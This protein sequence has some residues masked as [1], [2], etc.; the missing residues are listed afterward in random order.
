MSLLNDLRQDSRFDSV[1]DDELVEALMQEPE[2]RHMPPSI[3]RASIIGQEAMSEDEGKGFIAGL[4]SGLHGLGM[5]A[6]GLTA[7]AGEK[8]QSDSLY[9][10]GTSVYDSQMEKAAE[11]DLGYGLSDFFSPSDDMQRDPSWG[12]YIAYQVGAFLPSS[13]LSMGTGGV[14]GLAAKGIT[15]LATRGAVKGAQG[16][17]AKGA[18]EVARRTAMARGAAVGQGLG[19]WAGS[20]GQV[21]GSLY[22]ELGDSGVAITHGIVGGALESLFPASM[23]RVMSPAKRAAL[24]GDIS[25]GIGRKV[26]EDAASRGVLKNIGSKAL[27]GA[28]MEGGTEALQSL[29]EQH[30]KH[31]VETN[32]ES[33][34]AN[35]GE[36]DWRG[37]VDAWGAGAAGGGVMGAPGGFVEGSRARG[38][39]RRQDAIAK[40]KQEAEA[41]GGDALD[42]AMAGQNAEAEAEAESRFEQ[43]DPEYAAEVGNRVQMAMGELDELDNLSRGSSYQG[44]TRL[45]NIKQLLSR[46]EKSYSEGNVEQASRYTTRAE[47]IAMN[48]RARL[49]E[50]GTDERP[51]QV[52]G[53][54]VDDTIQGYIG[55]N[56]RYL[57]PGRD[58]DAMPG[59]SPQQ[60]EARQRVREEQ[61]A[62][63]RSRL[64]TD[65]GTIYAGGTTLDEQRA[66]GRERTRQAFEEK[67]GDAPYHGDGEYVGPDPLPE[68]I[69]PES[70]I[71]DGEVIRRPSQI[72]GRGT[73]RLMND[74]TIYAEGPVAG[75][76]NTGMDQQF[77]GARNTDTR[78][79]AGQ[80]LVGTEAERLA[81]WERLWREQGVENPSNANPVTIDIQ[82]NRQDRGEKETTYLP[83]NTPIDTQFRVVDASELTVSNTPDGRVNPSYPAELQP[84]DRTNAN[85]QVQ[86]RNIAARLNPE[87]LGSSTD[88]GTGA[89]IIGP[90]GV[91]ESGNGRAMAIATAYSQDGQKA[92][93]YRD[94][95]RSQAVAQGVPQEVVDS[96]EQPVLVRERATDIDRADFARRANE[97]SV[98]GMTS[99]EQAQ[100]DADTLTDDDIRAWTPDQSGDPLAASNRDFQRRFVQRLG[101]NEAARYTNRS[102]QASPELGVRMQRA[103]FAKAYSDDDMVEL[104]TE[105]GD[106]MRNLTASLQLAAPDLASARN[107]GS[108]EAIDAIGHINDAVRLVRKSRRDDISVRELTRQDDAFSEPVPSIVA[109]LAVMIDSNMR[110][111]ASLSE[112]M[113]S[114][115]RSVRHRADSEHSGALFEDTTTNEDV[116]NAAF[117][118]QEAGPGALE[119]DVS[120]GAGQG[121]QEAAGRRETD[122]SERLAD[123]EQQQEA[124]DDRPLL[125]DDSYQDE[126]Q[127]APQVHM[128]VNGKPFATKRSAEMST[129]FRNTPG[130]VA[131]EVDGGWG[132]EVPGATETVS[133][134]PNVDAP[135]DSANTF[136]LETQT[137]ESRLAKEQELEQAEKAEAER[138]RLL[139]ERAQADRDADDFV[140]S[141]SNS[142]ADMAMARGQEDIF[143]GQQQSTEQQR[144]DAEVQ[145]ADAEMQNADAPTS[146]TDDTG[147]EGTQTEEGTTSR[148]AEPRQSGERIEDFG[149]KIGGARKD[150]AM[151]V[152]DGLGSEVTASTKLSEAFPAPNY[153]KLVEEGVD[154]RAAAFVAVV[155]NSVPAKPRKAF[156]LQRWISNLKSAQELARM[157]LEKDGAFDDL[158]AK[159]STPE[160]RQV[161]GLLITAEV[162]SQLKPSL[163]AKAAKWRVDVSAGYTIFNGQK[164]DPNQAVYRLKDERGRDTGVWSENADDI[165]GKASSAI[166]KAVQQDAVKPKSRQ[167]PVNIYRNIQTGDR[168]IAFKAGSRVIRLQGGFESAS[169]AADYITE[170]RD[171]IQKQ[172][173]DMRAGPKMRGDSNAPREGSE[174]RD[175]DVTPDDFQ[176]AFGFRGVEFGNYVEGKRRQ[177]DLNRAYDAL[178]DLSTMMGVPPKAMS[179]DGT[180]G[181]AFG[182]RGRGGKNAAAA[183]YEPGHVVINLTK[184]D[185]AG[186]LAHEWFHALDNYIPHG[187]GGGKYQTDLTT[188]GSA[189]SELAERWREMRQALKDSGFE[190]RSKEFDAP[191]SKAY[192][193][194]PIEMAARAF[195]KYTK[196]KLDAQGVRNDYLVN[197]LAEDDGP[198]PNAD[199]SQSISSAFDRLMGTLE[200]KETARGVALYSLNAGSESLKAAL[201]AEDITAAIEGAEGLGDVE[202]VQSVSRLPASV[203]DNMAAN[204]IN[205]RDVSGVYVGDKMYVVADNVDSIEGGVRAAVHEAV[206]HKGIR[207]V[208]GESLD[209]VMLGLYRSL[210]NSKAGREALKEVLAAYPHLD[211]KNRDDRITIGEEMVAHMLEKGERPKAWQRAVAKIREMLRRAFPSVAW[212]YTDVLL[213]GEKS[214]E[215]LGREQSRRLSESAAP[216]MARYSQ[217]NG[218]KA[219]FTPIMEEAEAY[220]SELSKSDIRERMP[221]KRFPLGRTPPVLAALGAPDLALSV[222]SGVIYKA[223][224]G[225]HSVP[226]ELIKQLPELLHDP[227]MVLDSATQ[228][229]AFVVMVQGVDQQ[230]RPV[231]VP[232]QLNKRQ[233]RLEVN[234]V[235][236]AYGR[237]NPQAFIER[238]LAEGRG[239]YLQTKK[240]PE[241][242][243]SIR[244]QLPGE[245]VA[246]GLNPSILTPDDIG[247][248][249]V[250]YSLRSKTRVPFEDQFD[251][252]GEADRA[253]GGKIGSRTPP[254]RA[255]QWFKE[256]AD[257][258]SLK[259]RQGMVDKVA[260]F[261]EMDEQLYG[262]SMLGEN[263]ARSSWVLA[264][265]SNAASGALHALMHNGRIKMEPDEK[266]IT[267]QEGDAKGLGEVL[268]RLGS[269]AEIER[270][271]GWIA[272]N[273]AAKL[274]GEGRENLFNAEDIGAMK[275]WNRG[276]M[277]DG[278]SR[279]AVYQEVFN[280]FQTYRDDVLAIAEQ[281][282]II[283]KDQREMW[284]D[285]FYVPFYRLAEDDNKSP[286][287]ELATKGLS[288]QQAYKKL[289]GGSQNLNDLLQN[290]MMNF[291]HL[292]D[293]SLKNQAAVQAVHNAKELGMA[294]EV[295]E[296]GRDT[297]KT[298][299]V[300]EGGEK[301]FYE[302]DDPLVFQALTAMASPGMNSTAMKVMRGFKRVFTNMVTTTPQFMAANLIRDSLQAVATNNVS[303]NAF[304]NVV[305][306][307]GKYRDERLRAEMMASGASFNFGHLYGSNPDEMRAQL[308]RHMRNAEL[309][310]G[311]YM[312]P[313]LLRAGWEKW[314]AINNTAENVNRAA[315]YSQNMEQGK[316]ALA[317]A[318]E[319]RDLIDF[320]SHGAWPATRILI[321]IVPFLNARIQGLDKIYRSGVKPGASVVAEAFGY[322]KAGVTEKQAAGRFWAV[323]GAL[324]LATVALYLHNEEDEEY[325]KLEEWQKDSYWFFRVGDKAFFIPKPFEVGAIA[326]MAE[327]I[328]QQF[329]DDKATGK[330]FRQRMMHMAMD[331]FSF[332]PTPQ[333]VQPA[334]DIYANKDSFT[335]RPIEGMGMD[336]LSPELRKRSNTT[337]AAEWISKGLNSTVGAIGSPE[338]NPLALS[339]VQVDHLIGGYLG[340]V[341]SWVA[342]SG[343][344]A[345]RVATG[346]TAPASRWHEYQPI[347]RFYRDLGQEDFY[348]RY[349]TVFYEGLREAGRAYSDAKELRELGRTKEAME[350]AESNREMLAIR[351]GL[352]RA[353]RELGKINKQMDMIRRSNLSGEVKRQRMDRLRA[354]KNQLQEV[355]G[356]K[357]LDI[358]A[359]G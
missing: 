187:Q 88:A 87:R 94:Y 181:L 349:G 248:S 274:A 121:E 266:V 269:G 85:S 237:H 236:S 348:T 136:G 188:K 246:Q 129:R 52:Q 230:G 59:E 238:E 221:R 182:A 319:S 96:M 1:S 294:T 25:Q 262:E 229:S 356:K 3:A 180:L 19:A 118:R 235:A 277:A 207:G 139:D 234:R 157:A 138:Q 123:A 46:A 295:Q 325:Q 50:E 244:L 4:Q 113:A 359:A 310:D 143:S 305:S 292:L 35:Y 66:A 218:E 154:P 240:G 176:A 341:G 163:Y 332:N 227:I 208:L 36:I 57:P 91:V 226:M 146:R 134:A 8:L 347:R 172:I 26:L 169:N 309:I 126:A 273:R 257:R 17:A 272:G 160:Y 352:N 193:G 283:S 9:D 92:Q 353:Q 317:S 337:K 37:V 326:T 170:N 54:F 161:E 261:K 70:P 312:V 327:R 5:A 285:E 93:E 51:A 2:F 20:A 351:K 271:M 28:G 254:E 155:R 253:A 106:Q 23:L 214:R 152:M 316:G 105:Q 79:S 122:S 313:K 147:Q 110:S 282:G 64:L 86:V 98:S 109:D 224:Q 47:T 206:G 116:F 335:G 67:Q 81:E 213:L 286:G 48:L 83:D 97:S 215:Y 279:E 303:K 255:V 307:T 78:R 14:G 334:M 117:Q 315:I 336:R 131:V 80:E 195:E 321:D 27:G 156:R 275:G 145:N 115:G 297:S 22:G 342:G 82:P 53:E 197:I 225:K 103:I 287:M 323:T 201:R 132:Y 357:I 140:L 328:T 268:G 192:Y 31:Y 233:S 256:K 220:R 95:V 99:Y 270:F 45:N 24:K 42:Q 102:G 38:E 128:R 15:G 130:A 166:G 7:L 330:L 278:Q 210:P 231:L 190:E 165:R 203:L 314:N 284:R 11:H 108:Q 331:T 212:T 320:S 299:F 60:F 90:D 150:Q 127:D 293:A 258:A 241:W 291:N 58:P 168:F 135:V 264:R 55:N 21:T 205:P 194:T 65:D 76:A 6:G 151:R 354:V 39:L 137:E 196:D 247:N 13:A 32:G 324:T 74:G 149:E 204:G 164:F 144:P 343:D 44:K 68:G 125:A 104:A 43:A 12:E 281:S 290:T 177:S 306:G 298:T 186:S 119:T 329:T 243:Q 209:P 339:P 260:A 276:T 216:T 345:W 249:D 63:R 162:V 69:P 56:S 153:S 61:E 75:N 73:P 158:I 100:S 112:S 111:R 308:T 350:S 114:I 346:E 251:D 107:T 124:V 302:I 358:R 84:R 202:V 280:E 217:R 142:D 223:T 289:K 34:L 141:G 219:L 198:Y 30:A 222:D 296:S 33:L 265:M 189:R 199:E 242:L 259:I 62:M 173:D 179:L 49:A 167:T 148:A 301:K 228:E 89:P 322:G 267:I 184:A 338:D 18:A 288:R 333:A 211:P 40:A 355:W 72:E 245:G 29:V 344:V 41:Q 311:P 239:R 340:Q 318:F 71:Y 16:A 252:F 200:H 178:M 171:A 10:A 133:P 185:G 183:H 159:A 77:Q 300:M 263:I 120:R 175:G 304:K 174:V 250:R 232:L 101:N 191:R